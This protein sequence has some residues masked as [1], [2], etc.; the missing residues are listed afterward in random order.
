MSHSWIYWALSLTAKQIHISSST[1]VRHT[2]PRPEGWPVLGQW[3]FRAYSEEKSNSNRPFMALGLSFSVCAG[4]F[5]SLCAISQHLCGPFY[6]FIPVLKSVSVQY[7]NRIHFFT[8]LGFIPGPKSVPFQCLYF[9]S[10][11]CFIHQNFRLCERSVY[12]LWKLCV[13][14]MRVR[15]YVCM[16]VSACVCVCVCVGVI[17]ELDKLLIK[18]FKVTMPHDKKLHKLFLNNS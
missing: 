1:Y 3:L 2:T 11:I 9:S 8:Q 12:A 5:T 17:F 6:S 10:Q 4:H 7:W 15:V 18:K 16:C 13:M 14:Y